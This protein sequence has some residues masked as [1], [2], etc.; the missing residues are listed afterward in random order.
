MIYYRNG[1]KCGLKVARN[2]TLAL[3]CCCYANQVY[4][5]AHIC[6]MQLLI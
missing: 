5:L 3:P 2:S 4:L 1:L 6:K